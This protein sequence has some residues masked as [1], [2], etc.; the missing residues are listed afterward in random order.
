VK[1][2]PKHGQAKAKQSLRDIWKADTL[3]NAKKKF[4]LFIKIYELKYPK[5]REILLAFY[6]FCTEH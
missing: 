6:D 1:K 5:D 4:N 3:E 2:F